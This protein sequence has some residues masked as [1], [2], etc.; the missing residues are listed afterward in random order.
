M[1]CAGRGSVEHDNSSTAETR[2]ESGLGA[3]RES[4]GGYR[5]SFCV[6]LDGKEIAVFRYV[7]FLVLGSAFVTILA[8]VVQNHHLSSEPRIVLT[9]FADRWNDFKTMR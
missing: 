2:T 5:A 4:G 9:T 7:A 3:W 8:T 1:R 6:R